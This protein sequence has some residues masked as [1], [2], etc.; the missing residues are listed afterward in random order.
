VLSSSISWRAS[1]G[2][3]PRLPLRRRGLLADRPRNGIEDAVVRA[4]EDKGW[5]IHPQVGVS[6]FRVDLG[7]V[8]PDF[9]GRYLAGV[10]C[11]GATYRR[12]ATA[13]DRDR[14]RPKAG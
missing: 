7:I 2:S 11:D 14:L 9:P 5:E 8:H 6:F 1:S 10:E 13:R 4:L 3:R 12:S